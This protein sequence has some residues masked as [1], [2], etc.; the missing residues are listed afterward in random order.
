MGLSTV[1][2]TLKQFL[3]KSIVVEG[4]FVHLLTIYFIAPALF[5][6]VSHCT[7]SGAGGYLAIS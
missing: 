7:N 5:H 3:G 2:F 1:S 4:F 6:L